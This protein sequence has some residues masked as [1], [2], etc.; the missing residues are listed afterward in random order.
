MIRLRAEAQSTSHSLLLPSTYHLTPPSGTPS[1]LPIPAPTSLLP[2]LLPSTSHR[3]DIP[4]VTLPP[5]KR[6]G[7]ALGPTYEVGESSSATARP[8][9]DLW[10]DYGFITTIDM[11]IRHDLE[12]DVG[13]RITNTWDDIDTDEVY[14]RLDDEQTEQQLLAGWLNM[15][16]KDRRAHART[17]RLIKAKARMSQEAWGRSIDASELARIEVMLLRTTVLAQQSVIIELQAADHRR[18]AMI[19]EM[20]EADRRR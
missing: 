16:F 8:A 3:E 6:L 1:P 18:Q 4:E 2:L 13:Y 20:M 5:R 19:I 11:E 17:A 9:R 7:I 14:T 15:L 10:A 12:R